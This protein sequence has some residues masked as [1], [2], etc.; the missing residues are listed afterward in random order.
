MRE[1]DESVVNAENAREGECHSIS[2]LSASHEDLQ[3]E[4]AFLAQERD[5]ICIVIRAMVQGDADGGGV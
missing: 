2:A 4:L 5:V 3:A 1:T